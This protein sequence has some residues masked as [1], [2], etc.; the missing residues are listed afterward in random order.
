MN[1]ITKEAPERSR[2]SPRLRG[3]QREV[4]AVNQE[5]GPDQNATMLASQ[6]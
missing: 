6:A 4:L 5:E 2:A 1:K 3:T